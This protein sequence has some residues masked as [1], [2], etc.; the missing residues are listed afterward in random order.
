MFSMHAWHVINSGSGYRLKWQ[1]D[2]PLLIEAHVHS[3]LRPQAC[4]VLTMLPSVR[5]TQSRFA[6]TYARPAPHTPAPF[7]GSARPRGSAQ[8]C[9][10]AAPSRPHAQDSS[11]PD[12]AESSGHGG[13]TQQDS[14][15]AVASR[16]GV[17]LGAAAAVAA[18]LAGEQQAH[19]VQGLTAGRLPGMD[20]T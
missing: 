11:P 8:C 19:A 9:A 6:A 10:R 7:C 18:T 4:A 15:P 3:V 14:S 20:A 2:D 5:P 1:A 12:A 17:L 16:R 13:H